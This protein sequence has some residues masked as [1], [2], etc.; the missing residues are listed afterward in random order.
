MQP[1]YPRV[2]TTF[3]FDDLLASRTSERFSILYEWG[4]QTSVGSTMTSVFLSMNRTASAWT[5]SL[6]FS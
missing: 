3:S 2:V 5:A 4:L 6:I 1:W